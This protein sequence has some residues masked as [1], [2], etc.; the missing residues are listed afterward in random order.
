VPAPVGVGARGRGHEA[1]VEALLAEPR[2]HGCGNT[3]KISKDSGNQG[4]ARNFLR[5]DKTG[6]HF[7]SLMEGTILP[8][9]LFYKI[10]A[11]LW[12]GPEM[13]S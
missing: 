5:P 13:L 9:Y 3:E 7:R 1:A 8:H 2:G 6:A 4:W 11:H 12:D 10:A